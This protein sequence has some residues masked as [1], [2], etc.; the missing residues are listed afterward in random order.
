MT[1]RS[2][3]LWYCCAKPLLSVA[4]AQLADRGLFDPYRPVSDYLPEFGANGKHSITSAQLLTHTGPVPTGA[5][6]L[7]GVLAA[8]DTERRRRA[9]GLRLPPSDRP[10]RS[11]INYSQ[12]WAWYVLADLVAAI[13]GRAYEHYIESEI[14]IPARM[15]LT[16][17]RL[18]PEEFESVGDQ[19]PLIHVV[20]TSGPPVPTNWWSTRLATTALIPGVNTRGPVRDQGRFLEVLLGGGLARDGSQ[21]LSAHGVRDITSRHRTGVQDKFG[22]ADWGL[23]LRLECHQ[24]GEEFTSFSHYASPRT[25]GHEGLWTSTCFADPETGLAVAIN[26]NGKVEHSRHRERILRIGDAIY[27]DLGL[28]TS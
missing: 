15:D 17:L 23:G 25:F 9:Y 22:N 13:D 3:S 16:R 5:D 18:K 10:A 6:P 7:H 4:L 27:A 19:L 28:S 21:V 24:L 26:L 2:W 20:N 11:A 12:W 1:H 8:D 14:L